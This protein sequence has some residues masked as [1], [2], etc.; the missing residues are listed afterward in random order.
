MA[1][2]DVQIFCT[3]CKTKTSSTEVQNV[4]TKNGRPATRAKCLTCD[5]KKFL[6][7][8]HLAAAV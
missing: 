1:D 5:T 7:G 6:I 8:H 3:K 2:T 4:T